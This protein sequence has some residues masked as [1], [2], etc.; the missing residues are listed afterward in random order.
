MNLRSAGAAAHIQDNI[1]APKPAQKPRSSIKEP[2]VPQR[3]PPAY[4]QSAGNNIVNSKHTT[5]IRGGPPK[6][7][8][9]SVSNPFSSN[10]RHNPRPSSKKTSSNNIPQRQSN[11][12]APKRGP[13]PQNSQ[14]FPPNNHNDSDLE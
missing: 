8:T 12:A 7:M 11:A 1:P 6:E 10:N 13:V 9:P 14:P 4:L 5:N 3:I 2:K